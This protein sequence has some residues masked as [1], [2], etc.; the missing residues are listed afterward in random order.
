MAPGKPCPIAAGDDDFAAKLDVLVDVRPALVSF[1]FGLPPSEAVARC[2]DAG[3]PVALTVTDVRP[4]LA[5][6]ARAATCAPPGQAATLNRGP[7]PTQLQRRSLPGA[8]HHTGA[9]PHGG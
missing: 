4:A 1:A 6:A 9:G 7:P 5:A 2:H 8:S 3:I